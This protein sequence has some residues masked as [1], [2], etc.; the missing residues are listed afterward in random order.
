ME[1]NQL[2]VLITTNIPAPYMI[3]YLSELGK[4]TDLT[5]L[6]EVRRAKDRDASWYGEE[7]KV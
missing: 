5:V 2:R 1:N 4:K 7:N 3:G 6:F